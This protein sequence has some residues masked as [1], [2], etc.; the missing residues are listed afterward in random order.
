MKPTYYV[1]VSSGTVLDEQMMADRAN[2]SYE[3]V[4]QADEKELARLH[5]LLDRQRADEHV[6][7]A[8]TPIPYKTADHDLAM[9]TF[10]DQMVAMY[11]YI[12]EIGTEETRRFMDEHE[13]FGKLKN[14]DYSHPGY[15]RKY[16]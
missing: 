8:R 9:I 13:V 16:D 6:S 15:K 2:F 7:F 12:Y 11:S 4:V 10:N 1:S 3:F 14:P 5:E